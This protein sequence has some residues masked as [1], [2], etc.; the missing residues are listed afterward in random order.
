MSRFE[1]YSCSMT[2]WGVVL[3]TGTLL[4]WLWAYGVVDRVWHDDHTYLG[5]TVLG[6]FFLNTVNL[7]GVA[8]LVDRIRQWPGHVDDYGYQLIDAQVTEDRI[9]RRFNVSWGFSDLFLS[10]ALVGTVVGAMMLFQTDLANVKDMASLKKTIEHIKSSMGI[11]F[12]TTAIGAASMILL[13]LQCMVID[14]HREA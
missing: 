10:I 5:T 6:L 2:W 1:R 11:A 4:Y 13:R 8:L 12:T 14:F 7:G 9:N 3:M